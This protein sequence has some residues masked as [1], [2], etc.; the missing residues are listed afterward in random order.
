MK[1]TTGDT[2]HV[3]G[4]IGAKVDYAVRFKVRMKDKIDPDVLTSAVS[5]ASLRFP[6]FMGRLV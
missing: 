3:Y 2:M 6:Y 5:S 1:I 4:A